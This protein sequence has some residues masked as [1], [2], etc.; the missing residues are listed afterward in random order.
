MSADKSNSALALDGR[1]ISID[2]EHF[3]VRFLVPV[4]MVVVT[5]I[6]HLVAIRLLDGAFE[7][8]DPAC[9][10]VALDIV[11]LLGTGFV[12]ERLLKRVMPSRRYAKLDDEQLVVIDGRSRPPAVTEIAWDRKVNTLAWRFPV[13]RRSRVPKGWYCMAVQLL[14]DD[15]EVIF[16]T[17]KAPD[18]AEATRGYNQ[19]ARLR[20]RRETEGSTDL[21]AAAEQRRLL[22]LEDA[23]WQD[24]AE[25][26][27]NDFDALIAALVDHVPGWR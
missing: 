3:S 24:G 27:A 19:F 4:V 16:Y 13:R 21:H 14:Q 20:P 12:F 17:F 1:M 10:V 18:A 7:G 23:R 8:V 9:V 22:K 15:V 26:T 6:F 2:A 5:I 11:V 25:V